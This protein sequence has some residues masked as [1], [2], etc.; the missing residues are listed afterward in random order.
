MGDALEAFSSTACGQST[1]NDEWKSSGSTCLDT[2]PAVANGIVYLGTS[3][4]CTPGVSAYS[5]SSG[6]LLT[7]YKSPDGQGVY[8]MPTIANGELFF[9][10]DTTDTYGFAS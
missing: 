6:A 10:T 9:G 7:T 8:V 3:D 4:P 2:A 1:C 5:A